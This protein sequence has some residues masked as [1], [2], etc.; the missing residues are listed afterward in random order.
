MATFRFA[1][2]FGYIWGYILA[3]LGTKTGATFRFGLY[4]GT[5]LGVAVIDG[6]HLE[7]TQT[8]DDTNYMKGQ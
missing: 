1:L 5:R 3:T 6:L 2:H 4:L 7:A 8:S